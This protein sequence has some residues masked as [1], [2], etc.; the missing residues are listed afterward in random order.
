MCGV[1]WDASCSQVEPCQ[2]ACWG[3]AETAH[4]R[5]VAKLMLL[6]SDVPVGQPEHHF[7]PSS[8]PDLMLGKPLILHG[9]LETLKW[10]MSMNPPGNDQSAFWAHVRNVGRG[11]AA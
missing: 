8:C 7:T 3:D 2:C 1:N 4:N 10:N 11:E 6:M 9:D 5:L